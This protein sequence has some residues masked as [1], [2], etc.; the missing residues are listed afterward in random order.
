MAYKKITPGAE[1]L[2]A[3]LKSVLEKHA[4]LDP[5]DMTAVLAQLAGSTGYL[6][7]LLDGVPLSDMMLAI[8]INARGG[9][10]VGARITGRVQEDNSSV[11]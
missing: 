8:E 4:A 3:E 11:N 10:E 5:M 6:A 7:T 1:A 2:H 9:A